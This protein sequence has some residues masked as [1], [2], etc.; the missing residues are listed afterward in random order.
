MTHIM[1]GTTRD[2]QPFTLCGRVLRGRN[3]KAV[4]VG[5]FPHLPET[6]SDMCK[7]CLRKYW[8]P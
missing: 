6:P 5:H 7:H 8:I 1:I 3:A 4:G 2:R